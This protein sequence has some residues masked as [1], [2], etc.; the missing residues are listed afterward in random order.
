M[1]KR[2]GA[3]SVRG[4]MRVAHGGG[5]PPRLRNNFIVNFVVD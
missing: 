4:V 3:G 2:K 5:R 1:V